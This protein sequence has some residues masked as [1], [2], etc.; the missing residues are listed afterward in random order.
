[1]A[2]ISPQP[3]SQAAWTLTRKQHGVVTHGQLRELGLRPEA[4]QHRLHNGR[5]HQLMR[6]VY[7]VGRPDIS[8]KGRWQA[9]V[10]ACGP[11][12]LLSHRSAAALWGI[13]RGR[14][15]SI[16]VVVPAG[17]SKQRPGVRAHRRRD[18]EAPGRR[19]VDNIALT[20]PV[21]TLVDLASCVSVGQ[22]EAA[23]NEAD[24]REL[25]DP[26]RLLVALDSL[27]RRV[28]IGPLRKLLERPVVALSS[29]E[30]ER[31]FLP[32]AREAGLPVPRT[33]A[34]LGA[35]R[36]DFFWPELGLV[37]EADSLR[38]HRTPL[39]QA[40]DKRRDNAHVEAGRTTLRFT[41]GQI[42]HEP[43]YVRGALMRTARLLTR[44]RHQ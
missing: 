2:R 3:W 6:G 21:A 41:H 19:V 33:Q 28:G 16:E 17:L 29:T 38:Y 42:C 1:M 9:A 32:L 4:I 31:R 43:S 5:L 11:Q 20:H 12:A 27:P 24:H 15:E 44:G 22:L 25:V 13:H 30:L 26:E 34:Q 37:V 23:V 35:H 18:H 39:K 14:E 36:V 7:A 8:E 10:L 40:Q